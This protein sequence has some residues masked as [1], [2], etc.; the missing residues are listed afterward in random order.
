M[1]LIYN[2]NY[3]IKIKIK[4]FIKNN[5]IS[6][7]LILLKRVLNLN[8]KTKNDKNKSIIHLSKN[9]YRNTVIRSPHINKQAQ[10]QFEIRTYNN[11]VNLSLCL[12]T[13]S[14]IKL[15]IDIIY[16]NLPIGI[17]SKIIILEKNGY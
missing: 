4:S 7:F 10:E 17:D 1:K 15:I 6:D 9:I 16:Q 11:L 14:N 3:S 12:L 2:K 13:N 8:I 5:L